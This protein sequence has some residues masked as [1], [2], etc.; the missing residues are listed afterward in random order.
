[1]NIFSFFSFSTILVT[2]FYL[3]EK[4]EIFGNESY[5]VIRSDDAKKWTIVVK[6]KEKESPTI[7]FESTRCIDKV[8]WSFDRAYLAFVVNGKENDEF[9]RKLILLNKQ[10]SLETEIPDVC[11]YQWSPQ[12]NQ[13][14]AIIGKDEEAE[15]GFTCD[16]IIIFNADTK[17]KISIPAIGY[18]LFWAKH[19][20]VIYVDTMLHDPGILS[21]DPV[22]RVVVNTEYKGIFFSPD[23]FYYYTVDK[24]GGGYFSV[25]KS[26]D[27]MIVDTNPM[28][29][30]DEL[31]PL[32]WIQ[33]TDCILIRDWRKKETIV[34]NVNN[35]KQT[36][37]GYMEYVYIKPYLPIEIL[38]EKGK[39]I[40][41]SL[42]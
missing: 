11:Y 15:V 1:M 40:I 14:V 24:E 18:D 39:E 3:E 33:G 29:Q 9:G 8:F 21:Y 35:G 6:S 36:K 26:S 19:N 30:K 20:N 4:Y 23:G 41:D 38:G 7:L 10:L 12:A 42:K 28:F 27:Q 25:R 16:R 31:Y 34:V 13:L 37:V 32:G 2:S 5:S 22:K 17:E